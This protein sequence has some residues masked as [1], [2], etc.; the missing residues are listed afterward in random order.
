MFLTD[1]TKHSN[2]KDI[3][4]M[5]NVVKIEQ[6]KDISKNTNL[7][8]IHQSFLDDDAKDEEAITF[9]IASYDNSVKVVEMVEML[10]QRKKKFP[11]YTDI[12]DK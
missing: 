5:M 4:M 12:L 10:L 9:R 7:L 11:S 2:Y 1:D 3:V 8:K 6:R